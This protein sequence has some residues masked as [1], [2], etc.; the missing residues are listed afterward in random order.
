MKLVHR[1]RLKEPILLAAWPGMGLVAHR[2][3]SYLIDK[4]RPQEIGAIEV[5]AEDWF[6]IQSVSISDGIVEAASLPSGRL[7]AHPSDHQGP[8]LLLFLGEEQTVD[9][10]E[11]LF[12]NQLLAAAE[13]L[14][15]RLLYTF[16]AMPRRIDHHQRPAVWGV[17][18]DQKLRLEL[19]RHQLRI[20]QEGSI[21]GLNGV[22]LG[23]AK[24]R[25]W[26]G[27]CLLGEIPLYTTQ[28]ENPK[29]CHSIIEAL[30]A[31]TGIAVDLGEL[32]VMGEVSA[33][34]IDLLLQQ[35]SQEEN[36]DKEDEDESKPILN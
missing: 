20:L 8:D 33:T 35:L 1:P 24:K 18:T 10:K 13:K 19:Q 15:S 23:V 21:S 2:T 27:F 17:A 31:M 32:V 26:E 4:L 11:W 22:L 34:Q 5:E 29:S 14:G 36:E 16:A 6:A 25:G 3:V 28:M 12:S 9:G 30:S 7:F